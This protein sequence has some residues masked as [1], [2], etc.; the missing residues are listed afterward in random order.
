[1][2]TGVV[3]DFDVTVDP[4]QYAVQPRGAG[5][6]RLPGQ[7]GELVAATDREGAADRLLMRP[8]DVDAEVSEVADLGQL[9]EFLSGMKQTSGGSSDT[10]LN[11]PIAIPA[12]LPSASIPVITATPVGK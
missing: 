1:V 5:A 9:L 10:E 4:G 2:V 12:G 11:E 3:H 7:V 8:E 6:G